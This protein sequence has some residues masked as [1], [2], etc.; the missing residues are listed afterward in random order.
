MI[1]AL[2]REKSGIHCYT[3][4]IST[5]Q[6]RCLLTFFRTLVHS[7][8]GGISVICGPI[9]ECSTELSLAHTFGEKHHALHPHWTRIGEDRRCACVV[10]KSVSYH[11]D[12]AEKR[13]EVQKK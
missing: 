3:R 9:I 12:E 10:C 4:S 2:G 5:N 7:R 8:N 13:S 1:G 11:S 6:D